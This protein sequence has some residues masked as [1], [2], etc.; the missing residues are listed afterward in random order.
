M[1]DCQNDQETP[2]WQPAHTSLAFRRR[3]LPARSIPLSLHRSRHCSPS[4]TMDDLSGGGRQTVWCAA[5]GGAK[6]PK[7]A[8][9]LSALAWPPRSRGLPARGV[10]CKTYRYRTARTNLPDDLEGFLSWCSRPAAPSQAP[11]YLAASS[12]RAPRRPRETTSFR[13]RPT[14]PGASARRRPAGCCY[15]RH[16]R[17]E[18][19]WG[20]P[21]LN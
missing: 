19:G 17:I 12:P 10:P 21:T 13:V 14:C 20:I 2:L 5:G 16:V 9:T 1:C 3:P 18:L 4:M 7:P 8:S 15:R 6:H 11:K